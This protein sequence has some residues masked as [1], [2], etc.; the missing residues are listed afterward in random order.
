VLSVLIGTCFVSIISL[1]LGGS[2][3]FLGLHLLRHWN[4]TRKRHGWKS[5]QLKPTSS[6]AQKPE[7]QGRGLGRG[8]GT[9][10]GAGAGTG[11]GGAGVGEVEEMDASFS[12]LERDM[13][14]C[15]R[16]G[17]FGILLGIDFTLGAALN[18]FSFFA[19]KVW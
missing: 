3:F 10:T 15:R 19:M 16:F 9:E 8:T 2:Y 4:T 5:L 13:N 18:C 11:G 7:S 14:T 12:F 1:L 6:S 17:V